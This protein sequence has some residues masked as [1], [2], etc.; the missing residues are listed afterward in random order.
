MTFTVRSC[1]L[2]VATL[3]TPAF[4]TTYFLVELSPERIHAHV[5]NPD[6]DGADSESSDKALTRAGDFD[7][8]VTAISFW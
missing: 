5:C 8:N 1:G 2:V 6:C 3:S 7:C 4:S